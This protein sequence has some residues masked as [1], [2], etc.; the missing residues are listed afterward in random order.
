LREIK[1]SIEKDKARLKICRKVSQQRE[2]DE[3]L[4]LKL[5]LKGTGFVLLSYEKC[6]LTPFDLDLRTCSCILRVH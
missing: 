1:D 2:K 3:N 6:V 5:F 4:K